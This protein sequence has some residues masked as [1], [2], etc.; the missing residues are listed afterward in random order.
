MSDQSPL[1]DEWQ[2]VVSDWQS[3]PT[4]QADVDKLI[5]QT[6]RRIRR[7]KCILIGDILATLL[8]AGCFVYGLFIGDWPIF[9]TGLMLVL[10]L[11]SVYYV[12]R[13]IKLREG[14]WQIQ[15]VSPDAMLGFSIRRAES[16]LQFIQL[17]KGSLLIS[18]VG[19]LIAFGIYYWLEGEFR[20]WAVVYFVCWCMLFYGVS[21]KVERRRK[22]ELQE[23]CEQ[24]SARAETEDQ[25]D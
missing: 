18:V 20:L 4:Q 25:A 9:K 16:S 5:R 14:T 8:F 17:V 24:R 15:E 1:G 10:T 11:G 22:T 13:Q 12:Y 6:K 21:V 7:A 23:L 19:G 2:S 3:Q